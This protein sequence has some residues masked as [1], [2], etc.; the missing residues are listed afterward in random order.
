[1]TTSDLTFDAR[2]QAGV[3]GLVL[4]APPPPDAAAIVTRLEGG[5]GAGAVAPRPLLRPARNRIAAVA[6]VVGAVAALL[7]VRDRNQP[8]L[9][10]PAP[11]SASVPRYL[12]TIAMPDMTPTKW[13]HIFLAQ[14]LWFVHL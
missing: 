4:D 8:A 10:D 7:V 9:A 14:R 6:V 13:I 1:M 12:P 2:I 3:R 11:L 5:R